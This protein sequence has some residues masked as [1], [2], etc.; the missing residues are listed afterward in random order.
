MT[1]I[2][3]KIF[4]KEFKEDN[5]L[6]KNISMLSWIE[7]KHFIREKS[8][9]IFETFLPEAVKIFGAIEDH[10]SPRKKIEYIN[11]I[12]ESISKVVLFN[13]GNKTL[14]VEEEIPILSYCFV[15]AQLKKIYSNLKFIQIY[16][17]SLIE[18]G[19]ENQLVKLIAVC[20][21]IKDIKYKNIS[22]ISEDEYNQNCK[23]AINKGGFG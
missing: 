4:P 8:G 14:G 11:S 12:F 7:P 21:F 18:K 22:N 17:N 13:G 9:Y 19:Q 2:N 3:P 5:A 23:E 20:D 15:K 10:P 6:F 16:R 1:K